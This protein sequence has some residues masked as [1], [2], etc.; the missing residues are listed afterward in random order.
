MKDE[1]DKGNRK[2]K[3]KGGLLLLDFNP[4][5]GFSE[6][7]HQSKLQP[8]LVRVLLNVR[9][10]PLSWRQWCQVAFAQAVHIARSHSV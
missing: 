3:P 4:I 1:S 6:A 10:I 8:G 7:P 9:S 2:Q 5:E